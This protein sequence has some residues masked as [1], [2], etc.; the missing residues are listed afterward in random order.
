[1]S[2]HHRHRGFRFLEYFVICGALFFGG[3][4]LLKMNVYFDVILIAVALYMS[5][6]LWK[7]AGNTPKGVIY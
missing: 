2:H 5:W 4:G 7:E 6:R 3:L 1:M